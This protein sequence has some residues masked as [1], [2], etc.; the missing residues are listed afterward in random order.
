MGHYLQRVG[1]HAAGSV[2]VTEDGA[3]TFEGETLRCTHCQ[4][5]WILRPGSGI[6][7]GW[8]F[9]C[10]GPLCG[11]DAC[12]ARCRHWERELEEIEGQ[13]NLALAIDRIR[14]L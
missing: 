8:C 13:R 2:T 10:Q 11:K 4:A 14:T 12:A 6:E 1:P 7:R 9:R 3:V 5:Q